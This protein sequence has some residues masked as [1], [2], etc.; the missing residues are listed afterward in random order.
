MTDDDF[1]VLAFAYP[2]YLRIALRI[3]A[4]ARGIGSLH[5][6]EARARSAIP[7]GEQ[8]PP[9]LAVALKHLAN[10]IAQVRSDPSV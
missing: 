4:E 1:K 9:Q 7:T 5:E 10:D 2:G 3:L 8:F 6:F